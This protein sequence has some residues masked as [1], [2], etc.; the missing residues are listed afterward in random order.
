MYRFYFYYVPSTALG[1]E[2]K[3]KRNMKIGD[4]EVT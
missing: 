1:V 4:Y 3:T 2:D